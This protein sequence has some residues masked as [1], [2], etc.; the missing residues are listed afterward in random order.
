MVVFALAALAVTSQPV[1]AAGDEPPGEWPPMSG[2]PGECAGEAFADQTGLTNMG[3]ETGDFTGWR[4]DELLQGAAVIGADD[5]TEPH[6][7][8]HMARLGTT[9]E[10]TGTVSNVICQDFVVTAE[11][12][13]FAYNLFNRH[14]DGDVWFEVWL[15]APFL[16]LDS[17][18]VEATT[19]GADRFPLELESTGWIEVEVD[20]AEHLGEPVRLEFRLVAG[21]I[22]SPEGWVYLDGPEPAALS[23]E[24]QIEALI[25]A[26]EDADVH[27]ANPL[28]NALDSAL[29]HLDHNRVADACDALERFIRHVER[30]ADQRNGLTEVQAQA[31]VDAGEAIR[32]DLGC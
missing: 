8:Q 20:L 14:A 27:R 17:L 23:P 13:R 11:T 7:G 28:T 10:P 16:T 5:F 18:I 4:A 2:E 9:G 3:F 22:E 12:E 21:V 19:G 32:G 26:V 30:E 1:A 25:H 31:F 24:E 29:H 6:E 15:W